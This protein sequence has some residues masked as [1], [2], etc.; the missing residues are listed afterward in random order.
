MDE[1]L[2]RIFV[3]NLNHYLSINGFTQADMARKLHV[4]TAT[5]AN[6]CS[7]KIIPRIDKVQ[8]LC[9]WFGVQKSDLL[10][11]KEF[12]SDETPYYIDDEAR[13]MAEFLHKNPRYKVLFD[14]SRKVAPEDI[15]FVKRMIERMS[16]RDD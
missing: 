15:D 10:E 8:T 12:R 2:R 5:A 6:W 13:E 1:E 3:K 4:S 11:E 9:D 14:A 16:D 7:G